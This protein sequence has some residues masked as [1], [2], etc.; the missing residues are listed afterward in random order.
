[1]R[2]NTAP[3]QKYIHVQAPTATMNKRPAFKV[4][5]QMELR[6]HL[7]RYEQPHSMGGLR[8]NRRPTDGSPSPAPAAATTTPATGGRTAAAMAS[9]RT[10]LQPCPRPRRRSRGEDKYKEPEA[11][12]A[13]GGG[14]PIS[15]GDFSSR[16]HLGTD[17]RSRQPSSR[18]PLRSSRTSGAPTPAQR[19]RTGAKA[20]P[21]QN[22]NA[23]LA[24]R[25]I[26]GGPPVRTARQP[27][28]RQEG[29][30]GAK[31]ASPTR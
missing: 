15:D 16:S 10:P 9:G 8:S 29:A 6:F 30:L 4:P 19:R 14:D 12:S 21:P 11:R 18:S 17:D 2:K 28:L 1:M 22:T 23:A 27:P 7:R 24:A 20:G 3:R 25:D 5:L 31:P 13:D 26:L